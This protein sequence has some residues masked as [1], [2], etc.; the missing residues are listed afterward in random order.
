VAALGQASETPERLWNASMAATTA[1]EVAHLAA[2]ARLAQVP[3]LLPHKL[4]STE[5]KRL[6]PHCTQ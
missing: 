6:C 5:L 2:S 1:E 4:H 3:P